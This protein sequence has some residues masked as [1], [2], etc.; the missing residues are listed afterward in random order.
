MRV[1]QLL[2]Q[3]PPNFGATSMLWEPPASCA[4]G[5]LSTAGFPGL[6]VASFVVLI[7]AFFCFV[8]PGVDTFV[9]E[10]F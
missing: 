4:P 2:R 7:A 9:S 6:V 8:A 1:F 10:A 3:M 5:R